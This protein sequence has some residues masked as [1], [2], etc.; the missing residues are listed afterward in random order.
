MQ[1]LVGVLSRYQEVEGRTPDSLEVLTRGSPPHILPEAAVKILSDGW[2]RP[3]YYQS[4]G[5]SFALASFGRDGVP[6]SGG[7]Q[8][9]G[10]WSEYLA[11]DS[12]LVIIDGDWAQS[13]LGLPR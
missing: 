8:V 3:I 4:T 6:D 2:G 1:L 7:A 12:D 9:A 11:Y 10:G 5:S 13:P